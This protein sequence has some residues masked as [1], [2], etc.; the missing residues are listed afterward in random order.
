MVET[1]SAI[2]KTKRVFI[3][4]IVKENK[5]DIIDTNIS[6]ESRNLKRKG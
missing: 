4:L 3:E 6:F 5:N 2:D 1:R